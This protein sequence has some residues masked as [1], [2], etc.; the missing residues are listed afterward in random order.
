MKTYNRRKGFTLMEVLVVITVLSII[1]VLMLVIFTR[2]L[3]GSNKSQAVLAIK[4][5]GQAVLETMDKTIRNA[6]S[7][8]CISSDP[9]NTIVVRGGT[10]NYTRYRFVPDISG[11]TNGSIL[12]DNPSR[13][14]TETEQQF[15]ERVCD[16]TDS[17]IQAQVLTDTQTAT[18]VSVVSGSF[19]QDT[20]P[21]DIVTVTFVL[22]PA[23]RA[24]PAV[25]GDIDPI[26]FQTT[27]LL[28]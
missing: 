24:P 26:T 8:V 28:R 5:N 9:D 27:I 7:L 21:K 10:G 18:G 1:G 11:I 4:Q 22:K 23:V 19:K 14:E 3:R 12:Q 25:V 6:E 13:G 2:T 17:M 16:P 20:G 15:S